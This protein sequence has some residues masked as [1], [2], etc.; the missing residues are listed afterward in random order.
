MEKIWKF[1]PENP[2]LG[3]LVVAGLFVFGAYTLVTIPRE[4]SP[5]IQVPVAIVTTILP[6]ASPED[7]ELLV[8][9]KIERAVKDVSGIKKLTS[10]SRESISSVVVEFQANAPLTESIQKTKDAVDKAKPDLPESA[11]DPLVTDVNFADQPIMI[12]SVSSD[13]SP[14]AFKERLTVIQNDIED[15]PGVARVDMGGVPERHITIIAR[16]E[17]LALYHLSPNDLVRAISTSNA[18]I[19]IGAI[20]TGNI[21]YALSLESTLLSGEDVAYVPVRTPSGAVV[22]IGD[23]ALVSDGF[24]K[25]STIARLS[26]DGAPSEQAAVLTIYKQRGADIT[27]IT[28]SLR[29][30]FATLDNDGDGSAIRSSITF[31]AGEQILKD[32]RELSRV[33]IEAIVLVVLVLLLFLGP[34]E[35]LVAALSI[36]L[37]L[38]IGFIGLGISGNTIN[39]ISLFSLILGIGIVVDAAIVVTEAIH[40]NL[41]AEMPMREA[42]AKAIREFHVPLTMGTLTTVAA[43]VPLF[44]ISGITGEFISGIPFTVNALLVASIFVALALIPLIAAHVLKRKNTSI[45]STPITQE[46]ESWQERFSE[47][48]RM[49]YRTMLVWL[50]YSRTRKRRLVFILAG[51]F[52]GA[53]LLP[54][55][56]L[57][58]VSFFPQGDVEF[59][60]IDIELPQGSSLAESDFAARAVEEMLYGDA[61]IASFTTTVGGQSAFNQNSVSGSR[62]AN[63]TVNLAEERTQTSGEILEELRKKFSTFSTFTVHASQ[64]NNGPPSGAPV[65]ITFSGDNLGD[66]AR[67]SLEAS[68]LLASIPGTASVRNSEEDAPTKFVF[69]VDRAAA[70]E[71]GVSALD[72]A[73]ILRTSIVGATAATI[74]REGE[75][76]DIVVKVALNPTYTSLEDTD[77]TTIDALKELTINTARGPIPL[78][79][80]LKSSVGA[81]RESIAHENRARIATVSS[82]LREG[83]NA[84]TVSAAFA[85]TAEKE[86]VLPEGVS[87]KIG[88]EN[89]DVDQSFKDMF[90]AL[91]LALVLILIV[92]IVEFRSYLHSLFILLAVPLTLT[93]VLLGLA[94]MRQAISFPS[95]LGFVALAG[96]VV[97]HIIVLVDIFNR[98]RVERPEMPLH[99]VV[100]EGS[101]MR[102]RPVLLTTL[103]TAIGVVPLMFVSDLWRPIATAILFG[104]LYAVFIT[105]ALIP[106]LYLKWPGEVK[107]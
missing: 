73:Q 12:T 14:L 55:I 41:K 79:A 92:L 72:I 81:S 32:L 33:G 102:L 56:G 8:T 25:R 60:T 100:V 77:H 45:N 42:I 39:F 34:K 58:P 68:R 64:P 89:E 20:K 82:E 86:L 46:T 65:L 2:S 84:R 23:V 13:L 47:R 69:S 3:W 11:E 50:L 90:R 53:F 97:N 22:T 106:A 57:V 24:A 71:R 104:L 93:G 91:L 43:F 51:A 31:D 66:L 21:S 27:K 29:D 101:V 4:S 5:E 94:I 38:L 85:T 15:I 59:L 35:S 16:P 67:I 30:Y 83:A 7:V 54:V 76:T 6:G 80:F 17:A 49:Q 105:L 63:I 78:G 40:T 88:G 1:L 87:L 74:E 95:M 18:T 48:V 98:L 96:I 26:K 37:T 62:F 70:A 44:T 10:T 9:N 99:A 103:T 52:V 36:P 19:P 75:A 61:R 107:G 28:A